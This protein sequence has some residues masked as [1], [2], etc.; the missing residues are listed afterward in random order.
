MARTTLKESPTGEGFELR[1]PA[2]FEAKAWDHASKY[3]ASVDF[4]AVDC[5]VNVV[6]PAT[7]S[8]D[9]MYATNDYAG[10]D[11][12]LVFVPDTTH[13]LPLEKPR[14]CADALR[15]CL[16]RLGFL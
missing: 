2:Q 8:Q 7:K 3:A 12:S 14:A 16:I 1:S 5:P 11:V 9:P 13:L 15:G 4:G 10:A 6:L